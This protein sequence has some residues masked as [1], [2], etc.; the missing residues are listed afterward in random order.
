V[1][2][3]EFDPGWQRYFQS[4]DESI[5][6]RVTKKIWKILEYPNKRHLNKS[7]FFVDE[8]GQYRIIYRIFEEQILVR[9]YFV[10]THKEYE[11]WYKQD[12]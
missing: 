6:E 9:F 8:V 7:S 12:F 5:K 11:K 1:Y 2:K 10:G 4:L 3:A